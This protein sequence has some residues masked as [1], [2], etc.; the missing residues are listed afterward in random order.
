MSKPFG[1]VVL[2]LAL[3]TTLA[4]MPALTAG[5][6]EQ[7]DRYFIVFNDSVDRPGAAHAQVDGNGG[8][9]TADRHPAHLREY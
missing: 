3:V 9:M 7:D 1:R 2:A 6:A 4:V 8:D 5:A